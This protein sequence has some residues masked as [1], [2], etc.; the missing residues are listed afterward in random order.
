MSVDSSR[1]LRIG[2]VWRSQVVAERVLDRR[3]DVSVGARPD[4][5]V[6][7]TAKD[8]PGFPAHVTL[9]V[10]DHGAYHIVLPADPSHKLVLRGGPAG[11][12]GVDKSQVKT[13]NGQRIY[14]IEAF[15]GGSVS[16]GDLIVMFQFV[17]GDAIPTVTREETVLRIGLVHEDRLL[18]D[19]IFHGDKPVV[20][21]V[22]PTKTISLPDVD[23]KGADA[24][25]VFDKAGNK[26]RA[27]IP[28]E[29]SFRLAVEGQ[30]VVDNKDGVQKGQVKQDGNFFV[31]DVPLKARGR[32]TMGPYTVLFQVVKQSVTVPVFARKSLLSKL[33]G[34][35]MADTVWTLSLLGAIV[36]IG[37]IVGQAM[38]FHKTTGRF[39]DKS[40]AEEELA[41]TTFEVLI[42]EKEEPKD[43]KPVV[44]IMSDKAKEETKKEIEK[45]K[46]PDKKAPAEKP[47][48]VGKTVDPEQQKRNDREVLKNTT[49]AGALMGN[50]GAAT[51]L[52][53]DGDGD[54]EGTVTAKFGGGGD[55]GDGE[56]GPGKGGLQLEG[57]GGGGGTIEKVK[58]KGGGFG[59]R[60]ADVAKV[61]APVKKELVAAVKLG[62]LDGEDDGGGG[63]SDI[64]KKIAGRA[65]AVKACYE[66]ALRDN[67]DV[68]GKVKVSFTVGTAGT[69]TDVT[70]S[71]AEGGFKDCIESKFKSIRGLPILTAPKQFNQS[72][73]F[74]KS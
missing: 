5:T 53:A 57:G 29:S 15:T 65:A 71:G 63:K 28:K 51:K 50:N 39:L 6:A 27:R 37:S 49:V 8:Y 35:F 43:E 72:F 38:L 34:P 56:G 69:I 11:N 73:V 58:G 24:S 21:G 13:V 3:I 59:E 47:E 32:C 18:S 40:S 36:L 70:V 22:G 64:A 54:T 60:K 23:Y 33:A 62:G 19:E 2:V 41:H 42:E 7:V 16:M 12:D 55:G 1:V 45:D 30:P 52:F 68:S 48:S 25:F 14:P 31:F 67:P 17:R 26:F 66:A 20:V 74:T 4:S 9:A 10:V 44:D 46:K 61:D